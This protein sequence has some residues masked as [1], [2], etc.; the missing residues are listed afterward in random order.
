[1]KHCDRSLLSTPPQGPHVAWIEQ[2]DDDDGEYDNDNDDG[3]G[4]GGAED[5]DGDDDGEIL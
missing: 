5:D 2:H 4:N 1:M 3:D